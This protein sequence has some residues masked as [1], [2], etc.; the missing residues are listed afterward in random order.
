[1]RAEPAESGMMFCVRRALARRV[2]V[3]QFHGRHALGLGRA[4][5]L[6]VGDG[7][8]ARVSGLGQLGQRPTPALKCFDL[9]GPCRHTHDYGIPL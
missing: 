1:M 4:L 3:M 9:F 6:H 8:H 7:A 2:Q 5:V